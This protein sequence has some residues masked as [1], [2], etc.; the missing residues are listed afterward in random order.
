M[1]AMRA[2][3]TRT[4]IP[5]RARRLSAAHERPAALGCSERRQ[6]VPAHGAPPQAVH[7]VGLAAYAACDSPCPRNVSVAAKPPMGWVH[8]PRS[9]LRPP[10]RERLVHR[11]QR[12]LLRQAQAP[13]CTRPHRYVRPPPA[14]KMNVATHHEPLVEK[15]VL[16]ESP[17][18]R[19]DACARPPATPPA[20]STHAPMAA[21]RSPEANER[22]GR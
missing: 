16:Q 2:A 19:Q 12:R 10:C 5:C 4:R 1:H 7:W 17:P 20:S 18:K 11:A 22:R 13:R 9:R 3:S 15:P 21:R 6:E 14:E 8:A